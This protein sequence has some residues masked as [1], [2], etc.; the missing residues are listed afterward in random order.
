VRA[1][2]GTS[3]AKGAGTP[4]ACSYERQLQ[5]KA[6]EVSLKMPKL[7]SLPF[8][9]AIIERYRRRE[10]SVEE[11]LRPACRH[12]TARPNRRSHAGFD[13]GSWPQRNGVPVGPYAHTVQVRFPV[14]S[15]KYPVP[16]PPFAGYFAEKRG[17][18][19]ALPRS[20]PKESLQISLLTGICCRER[21]AWDSLSAI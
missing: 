15:Y 17:D 13:L 14:T 16:F 2:A 19:V 18:G 1:R 20:K 9:T 7:R 21:F 5:T 12:A 3:G 4:R 6:G 11:S 10:S 8:E